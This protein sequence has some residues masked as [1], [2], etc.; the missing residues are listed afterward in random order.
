MNYHNLKTP[1]PIKMEIECGVK[2]IAGPCT[3]NVQLSLSSSIACV[4]RQITCS[5]SMKLDCCMHLNITLCR[6]AAASF[7]SKCDDDT[8]LDCFIY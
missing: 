3:Y 8:R 6:N 5:L 7:L 2:F 1:R 4:L